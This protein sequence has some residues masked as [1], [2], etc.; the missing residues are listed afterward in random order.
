MVIFIKEVWI[1]C[2]FPRFS[3]HLLIADDKF[4]NISFAAMTETNEG[5]DVGEAQPTEASLPTEAQS[6]SDVIAPA[7][8]GKYSSANHNSACLDEEKARRF[9]ADLALQSELNDAQLKQI[10]EEVFQHV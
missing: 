10:E 2:V 9:D 3:F 7:E 4:Y 5:N 8:T 6:S 1:T